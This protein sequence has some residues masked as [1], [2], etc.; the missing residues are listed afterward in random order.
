MLLVIHA[1]NREL[2]VVLGNQDLRICLRLQ[3]VLENLEFD[4]LTLQVID[5]RAETGSDILQHLIEVKAYGQLDELI[6]LV[7]ER[8][9]VTLILYVLGEMVSLVHEQFKLIERE[10]AIAL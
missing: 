8:E 4:E 9:T 7:T 5:R 2:A 6:G 3:K 1:Y 10:T